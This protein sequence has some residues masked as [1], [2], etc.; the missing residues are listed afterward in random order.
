M[1]WIS[2]L[3]VVTALVV[4]VSGTS[5]AGGNKHSSSGGSNPPAGGQPTAG[6]SQV[7]EGVV[8]SVSGSTLTVK[9]DDGRTTVVDTDQVNQQVMQVVA[10]GKKVTIVGDFAPQDNRIK[11][12]SIRAAGGDQ[13]SASPATGRPASKDDCKD[14]G[15]E[16][17][18]FKNQG[19]CVSSVAREK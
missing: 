12:K 7:I 16:R 3:V 1:K 15:W 2:G 4:G 6:Q 10:I 5:V 9:T 17:Y 19:Q 14:G 18:G 11:A 13:G 8:E